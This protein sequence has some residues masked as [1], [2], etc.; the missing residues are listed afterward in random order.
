MPRGRP[1]G[2]KN[3]PKKVV[4]KADPEKAVPII[5]EKLVRYSKRTNKPLIPE[6][7]VLEHDQETDVLYRQRDVWFVRDLIRGL[8]GEVVA[9]FLDEKL[10]VM[11][12]E[13][14]NHKKKMRRK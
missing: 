6:R 12:L 7:F 13:I 11:C 8:Y 14:L 4:L 3:K 5:P 2:S 1:K 9:K 10:A